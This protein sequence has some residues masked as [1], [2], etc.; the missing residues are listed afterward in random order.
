MHS[1]GLAHE[2]VSATGSL[3][4]SRHVLLAPFFATS[5]PPLLHP[6][7]LFIGSSCLAILLGFIR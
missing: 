1:V 7:L 4:H 3:I 2:A 5:P 6:I